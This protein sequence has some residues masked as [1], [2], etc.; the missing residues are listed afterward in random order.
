MTPR[1]LTARQRCI[2]AYIRAYVVY[3][4]YPPCVREIGSAVALTSTSSVV[5]QLTQL[6][7]KG[8]IRRDPYVPRG[9]A[10]TARPRVSAGG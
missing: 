6:H 1:K 3:N 7:S 4:G 2:L 10:V 9:I 5:Y 8:Y